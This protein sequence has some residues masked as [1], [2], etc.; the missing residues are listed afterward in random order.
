MLVSVGRNESFSLQRLLRAA[1]CSYL[2][3]FYFIPFLWRYFL[4]A[5]RT[6]TMTTT[7]T[8]TAG[9]FF[10]SVITQDH[11]ASHW[12]RC[13]LELGNSLQFRTAII[14]LSYIHTK[15]VLWFY[16]V[17]SNLF[18]QTLSIKQC[19]LLKE[20]KGKER[21]GKEFKGQSKSWLN[22]LSLSH[23]PN[24]KHK[25][26]NRWAIASAPPPRKPRAH[27]S[28]SIYATLRRLHT[29]DISN[30]IVTLMKW[31]HFIDFLKF[32]HLAQLCY[33]RPIK[34]I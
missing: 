22:Q 27:D 21:K 29:T 1:R 8:F 17:C 12:S 14:R 6:T 15:A 7:L 2:A 25:N 13:M 3:A 10:T 19:T 16:M 4:K 23:L 33:L 26:K 30:Q 18:K 9:R 11:P 24:K 20:R 32:G 34:P 28:Q 31:I 5:A